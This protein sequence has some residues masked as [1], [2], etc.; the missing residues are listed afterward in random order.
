MK[1]A[2]NTRPEAFFSEKKDELTR[3]GLT[4]LPGV[5]AEPVVRSV[6]SLITDNLPLL[7]NTRPTPSS[8]HLAGFHRYPEFENLHSLL[9]CNR[10]VS[11]FLRF[12][13]DGDHLRN[14]GISDITIN[15]SQ[16]WHKDLLRGPYES[17]LEDDVVWR[18]LGEVFRLVM[19]LQDSSGLKIVPGSH[20][21]PISLRSDDHAVPVDETRVFNV[22]VRAGD[23]VVMDVRT[24]HRG[25]EESDFEKQP[26]LQRILVATTL[27]AD[28][29]ALTD[30][31]EYGNAYRLKDWMQRNRYRPWPASRDCR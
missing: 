21:E 28:S 1:P 23:V 10:T 14:I 15:R 26:D 30:Q 22:P 9:S 11:D 25:N 12:V 24:S 19:Y 16:Q 6:R 31:L 29:S 2:E 3:T 18:P 13:L 20:L 4:V 5:F 17:Y 7:R 8:L 27:G